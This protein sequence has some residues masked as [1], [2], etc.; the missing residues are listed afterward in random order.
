MSP[1]LV[2]LLHVDL[3]T[4]EEMEHAMREPVLLVFNARHEEFV[5]AVAG[6]PVVMGLGG[7]A[8]MR[9]NRVMAMRFT[10]RKADFARIG[11]EE[12]DEEEEM[13]VDALLEG[14]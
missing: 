6:E 12:L 1:A 13:D 7:Y 9:T 11:R 4:G 3:V 5:R 10:S 14:N 8:G 2:R